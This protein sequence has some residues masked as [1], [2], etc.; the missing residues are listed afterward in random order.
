[1][2]TYIESNFGL[3]THMNFSNVKLFVFLLYSAYFYVMSIYYI[4]IILLKV[5]DITF[6]LIRQT[7]YFHIEN[8]ANIK[9]N[10]VHQFKG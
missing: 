9:N 5:Y 1:M 10:Y 4:D 3:S 8:I 7:I 6:I 2:S